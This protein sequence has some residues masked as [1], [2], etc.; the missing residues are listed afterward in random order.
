MLRGRCKRVRDSTEPPQSGPRTSRVAP[1][2]WQ[3]SV[4]PDFDDV[5][6]PAETK[7][8]PVSTIL[9]RAR[10][11]ARRSEATFM[12]NEKRIISDLS[13]P[14]ILA[15]GVTLRPPAPCLSVMQ[16][17]KLTKP[18]LQSTSACAAKL[19]TAH[20]NSISGRDAA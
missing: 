12:K 18:R 3:P 6:R 17:R 11:L 7:V 14:Y 9:E 15:I 5:V 10:R 2:G 4:P 16:S 8:K 20:L 13:E 1:R 19:I